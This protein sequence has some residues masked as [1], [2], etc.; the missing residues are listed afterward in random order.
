MPIVERRS[1]RNTN[2]LQHRPSLSKRRP[3]S[4]RSATVGQVCRTWLASVERVIDCTIFHLGGLPLGPRS[5][6]GQM[7]YYPLRSTILQNFGM[8]AQTVYQIRVTKVFQF[9]ALGGLTPGPKFTKRGDDLADSETYHTAK[10]H[11]TTPTHA[12]DIRYQ[13]SCG[14]TNKQTEKQ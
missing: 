4:H 14:Q 1:P 10:F 2:S 7:T 12:R 6:K 13:N 5:P 9:L 11:R 3:V 8:I